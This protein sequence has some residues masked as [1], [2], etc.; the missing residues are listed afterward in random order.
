MRI[1]CVKCLSIFYFA[2]VIMCNN[3]L[4][5]V[6]CKVVYSPQITCFMNWTKENDL[7][8]KWGLLNIYAGIHKLAGISPCKVVK[9]PVKMSA[10]NL[11][12]SVYVFISGE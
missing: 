8:M 5:S 2:F 11:N 1:I 7:C 12:I 4:Y 9:D 6:Q 10:M 3:K